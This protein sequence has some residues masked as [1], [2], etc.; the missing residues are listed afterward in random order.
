VSEEDLLTIIFF[1]NL[2]NYFLKKLKYYISLNEL[3]ELYDIS[4][5]S[6]EY[7]KSSNEFNKLIKRLLSFGILSGSKRNQIKMKPYLLNNASNYDYFFMALNP[8]HL[9]AIVD[10]IFNK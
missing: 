1:D 6:L 10:A 8:K 4:C 3:K 5:E 2:S 7:K 9:K